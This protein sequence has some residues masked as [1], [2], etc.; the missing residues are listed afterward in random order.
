[1]Q[2]ADMAINVKTYG[3]KGDGVTD[4]TE[5]IQKA[6]DACFAAGG[7]IVFFPEGKYIISAPVVK[8]AKVSLIGVGGRDSIISWG[9]NSPGVVI[10]TRNESLI[11]TSIE[12]L[13]L[14]KESNV[15]SDVIG[16]FGGA[17]L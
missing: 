4:D 5:A 12:S 11:H 9:V 8:K 1:E 13:Q 10:D 14:T 3:A 7:G 6:I 15:T 2:L 17:T 16:I